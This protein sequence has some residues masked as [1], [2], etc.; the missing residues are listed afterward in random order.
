MCIYI[1]IYI[2]LLIS[3]LI[4]PISLLVNQRVNFWLDKSNRERL[5]KEEISCFPDPV[6]TNS[7]QL[8]SPPFFVYALWKRDGK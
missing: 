1:Y 4:N 8:R 7:N 6:F 5:V 3:H 2:E